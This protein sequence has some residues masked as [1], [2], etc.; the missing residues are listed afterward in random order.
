MAGD[1]IKMRVDLLTSPKVVRMSSALSADR[2]RVI[3]GLLS[4]WSL[5]DA[6]STDGRLAGYSVATLNEFVGWQ[7]FGESMQS[8]DWLFVDEFGLALPEFDTHNG[9][10][11]KRRAQEADRKRR[12]RER[13]RITASGT[14]STDDKPSAFD[15]DE[16]GT[17]V[18]EEKNREDIPIN[19]PDLLPVAVKPKG[20]A[21]KTD[22][23]D[24][25]IWPSQPTENVM[26]QWLALRKFKKAPVS[27]IVVEDLAKE[28]RYAEPFGFSVDDCLRYAV[29]KNWRGFEFNWMQGDP[30]V[31][32]KF[33]PLRTPNRSTRDVPLAEQLTDR[34]WA[35]KR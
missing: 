17:R 19:T 12:E 7:G 21:K 10:P 29:K 4:A 24:F 6:H 25:S 18:R 15:A 20:R 35:E 30:E 34:S 5:F 2:F 31:M 13:D 23:V 27:Q 33:P 1:W 9:A 11:A 3:G 14:P 28:F 22:P 16:I 32:A 8:V 26:S